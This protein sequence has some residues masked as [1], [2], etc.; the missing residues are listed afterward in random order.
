MNN[1]YSVQELKELGL[2]ACGDNVMISRKASIYGARNICIGDHVRIDDF[3]ILSGH[4]TIGS[5]VHI[6][7]YC[8]LYGRYKIVME[9][10]TGISARVTLYSAVDDFSG[11]FMIGPLVPEELTRVS[12]GPVTLK[13]FVQIGAG[14]VVFPDLTIKQGSAIG[15]MSLITKDISEWGVYAGVPAKLIKKRKRR[16][17]ELERNIKSNPLFGSN[18]NNTKH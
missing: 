3:C 9:D 1:F 14:C 7:T 16:I 10:Y 11:E 5:Y 4:I 17:L 15:S 18:G 2:K 6:S 13:K 12:G 8:A